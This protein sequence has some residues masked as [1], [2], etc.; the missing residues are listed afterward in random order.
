MGLQHDLSTSAK[1]QNSRR[2]GIFLVVISGCCWGFHGILIK[3]AIG[4]GISFFQVFL[5]EV[6][7]ATAFFALFYKR[8]FGEL[9]PRKFTHWLLLGAIG[10]VTIGVGYFLFLSFS[11]GPVAIGATLMFMYLPVVYAFTLLSGYQK[12]SAVKLA[13]IS[14]VLLGAVFSTEILSTFNQPGALPAVYTAIIASMCYAIV[15]IL[16]PRVAEYTTAEFRSFSISLIGLAGS[17]IVFAFMPTLW[18]PIGD[19]FWPIFG[20]ALVLSAVGQT[21]PVITLMK[22][23][24]ITGS[25]LG[26]VLATIELPI[27][28]FASAL[29]LGESFN[30]LKVVGVVL[31]LNGIIVYNRAER[32]RE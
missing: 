20:M 23:L 1:V 31:V 32:S 18:F 10:L 5:F 13:S 21:L 28:V 12:F 15:F 22:G 25:S 6:L 27:A 19:N 14:L 29:L 17:L 9:R 2:K 4:L 30:M 8:F 24:P 11:L 3:Y 26:G 7:F 16:T